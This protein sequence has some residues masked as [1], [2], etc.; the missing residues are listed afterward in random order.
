MCMGD[1]SYNGNKVQECTLGDLKPGQQY[2]T[3][4]PNATTMMVTTI[5]AEE[6]DKPVGGKT[7]MVVDLNTGLLEEE[8]CSLKL[9]RDRH[10]RL[11]ASRYLNDPKPDAV[12]DADEAKNQADKA[13]PLPI[14]DV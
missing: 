9:G 4:F 11:Y 2:R 13:F 10:G 14:S 8:E 7:V 6:T 3:P 1:F 12:V 5:D